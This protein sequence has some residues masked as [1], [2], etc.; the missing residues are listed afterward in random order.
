MKKNIN[1]VAVENNV[2]VNNVK[3]AAVFPVANRL[4]AQLGISMKEAFAMA[5]EQMM[6]PVVEKSVVAESSAYTEEQ[7]KAAAVLGWSEKDLIKINKLLDREEKRL[8]KVRDYCKAHKEERKEK[9]QAYYQA[10]KE[11]LKEKSRKWVAAHKEEIKEKAKAK[12]AAEKEI[13]KK[14]KEMMA[15]SVVVA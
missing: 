7:L 1:T 3:P 8:A 14:Y 9:R 13:I 12:R 5:K 6:H 2:V 11:K 4:K 10:N 15:A